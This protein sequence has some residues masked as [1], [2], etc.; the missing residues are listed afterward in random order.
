MNIELIS[1][2]LNYTETFDSFLLYYYSVLKGLADKVYPQPLASRANKMTHHHGEISTHV[3]G[4]LF[5][6]RS[7]MGL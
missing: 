5:S 2:V 1:I 6:Q 3:I 4:S 7:S